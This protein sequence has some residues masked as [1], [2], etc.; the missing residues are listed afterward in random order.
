MRRFTGIVALC[1]LLAAC[2]PQPAPDDS[3]DTAAASGWPA[4]DFASAA[5]EGSDVFQLD[6][7][8]RIDIVVRRDG[9]LARFGHD[10]VVAVTNPEGLLLLDD[11]YAESRAEIRFR[12]D[13]LDVDTA[14]A[15]ERYRLDTEPDEDA[16]RGTRDNLES[17]VLETERWPWIYVEF[18]AFHSEGDEVSADVVMIVKDTRHRG[19]ESFR[20]E[21]GG[22]TVEVEGMF[23]LSQAALGLEPFSVLGGGL[24]VADTLEIHVRFQGL[25]LGNISGQ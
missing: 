25:L 12:T 13:R 18:G 14:A 21:R 7:S 11:S 2:Q 20:L 10:H 8:S 22:D 1:L 9:P 6:P 19:R 3:P 4:F 23:T 5:A 24:R 16:I 15:R 17:R